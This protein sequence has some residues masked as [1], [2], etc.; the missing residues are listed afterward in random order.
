MTANAM[1]NAKRDL[2]SEQIKYKY[3]NPIILI[4][5]IHDLCVI[6]NRKAMRKTRYIIKICLQIH[7]PKIDYELS[8]TIKWSKMGCVMYQQGFIFFCLSSS[9]TYLFEYS[10]RSFLY[11]LGYSNYSVHW[12]SILCGRLWCRRCTKGWSCPVSGL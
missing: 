5:F 12:I 8:N 9:L 7:S 10:L 4:H 6:N 3:A 11:F 1:K 2:K